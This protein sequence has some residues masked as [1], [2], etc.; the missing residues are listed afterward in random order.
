[1]RGVVAGDVGGGR[2]RELPHRRLRRR[3]PVEL[4]A[5][6]APGLRRR[7]V[8]RR[9]RRRRRLLLLLHHLRRREPRRPELGFWIR[10][11]RGFGV[12]PPRRRRGRVS[13]VRRVVE[14][15]A[16]SLASRD[17]FG[18]YRPT[19]AS[20]RWAFKAGPSTLT[21]RIFSPCEA[22]RVFS[23]CCFQTKVPIFSSTK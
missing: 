12:L 1:M 23:S 2:R 7:R 6:A 22:S 14:C 20:F 3:A 9:R 15:C 21:A 16:A 13:S 19:L 11:A 18:P 4:P 8:L 5:A 17:V 10:A